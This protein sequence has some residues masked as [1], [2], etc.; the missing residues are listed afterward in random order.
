MFNEMIYKLI[1]FHRITL[2]SDTQQPLYFLNEL[3]DITMIYTH[4]QDTLPSAPGLN[5]NVALGDLNN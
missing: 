5:I 3:R 2:P 1:M 4:T